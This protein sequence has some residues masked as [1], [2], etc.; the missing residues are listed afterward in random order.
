MFYVKWFGQ[1]MLVMVLVSIV[2]LLVPPPGIAGLM[3]IVVI[4]WAIWLLTRLMRHLM[5][6]SNPTPESTA[7]SAPDVSLGAQVVLTDS[8]IPQAQCLTRPPVAQRVKA[9]NAAGIERTCCPR[10]R[11]R[12]PREFRGRSISLSFVCCRV[13]R[14]LPAA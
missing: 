5:A 3:L 10:I 13:R 14:R 6:P 1:F 11:T 2:A 9:E 4:A 8:L 12:K 7:D